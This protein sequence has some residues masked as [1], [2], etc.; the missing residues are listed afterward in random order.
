MSAG[1]TVAAPDTLYTAP[2]NTYAIVN[3]FVGPNARVQVGGRNIH[4]V[5]GVA[6]NFQHVVV[7]P[8][9]SLIVTVNSTGDVCA[10]SGVSFINNP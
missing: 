5:A 4:S 8:G 10:I 9:Q 1:E 7:G 3:L 6:Q 2:A